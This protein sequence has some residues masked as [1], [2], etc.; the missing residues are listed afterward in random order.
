M[1]TACVAVSRYRKILKKKWLN[2]IRLGEGGAMGRD[3]TVRSSTGVGRGGVWV[4]GA[5]GAEV[6]MEMGVEAWGRCDGVW[7]A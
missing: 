5:R 2:Q 4:G 6:G 1:S 7:C 3:G